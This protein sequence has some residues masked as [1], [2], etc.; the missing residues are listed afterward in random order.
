MKF[1]KTLT[2][3]ICLVL[4][5]EVIS[6]KQATGQSPPVQDDITVATEK[7]SEMVASLEPKGWKLQDRVESF[8][9]VN[10]YERI[11]GRAEYYLSYDMV[12]AVFG[13]FR[14]NTGN[15]HSIELSIFNLG[16]PTQAFGAFSGERSMGAPQ[17]KL[18]RDSYC[19]EAAF[20][21]WQGQYYIQVTASDT[22]YEL[23][24]VCLDL[25]DKLTENL[26]DS[27]QPVWGLHALP[28][29]DRVRQ[30]VQYFLV[31][32]LGH[33]FL[34]DTYTAKYL[35]DRTEIP[36][37]LSRQDSSDSAET[38]LEKFKDHVSK[39]G[40]GVE[41][42][43]VD[44]VEVVVCDMGKYYDVIFRK[45]SLVAGVTG[46]EDKNSAIEASVDFWKQLQV[47]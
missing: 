5:A 24:Q 14:R 8:S 26:D 38:I 43:T 44:G 18:G 37:F 9:P 30:S 22:T 28:A 15:R 27:S 1:S 12:W 20:Y 23:Q 45:G 6:K 3:L 25:A 42:T 41:T 33:S 21:I 4:L 40:E 16:N 13:V 46:L 34:H 47:E 35:K 29:K 39:Y 19:S 2:I 32:A 31:D 17:L 36:V 10:L 11:N 7:I